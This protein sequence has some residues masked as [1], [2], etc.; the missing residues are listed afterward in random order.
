ML[1]RTRNSVPDIFEG[2]P[3][4]FKFLLTGVLYISVYLYNVLYSMAHRG[5]VFRDPRER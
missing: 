3:L 2:A 5:T 4:R 1:C